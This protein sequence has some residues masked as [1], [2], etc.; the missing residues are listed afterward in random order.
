MLNNKQQF[1]PKKQKDVF[2]KDMHQIGTSQMFDSTIAPKITGTGKLIINK[3]G[4]IDR[5]FLAIDPALNNNPG[6]IDAGNLLNHL[7]VRRDFTF[8][9]IDTDAEGLTTFRLTGYTGTQ[10]TGFAAQIFYYLPLCTKIYSISEKVNPSVK[11]H[12]LSDGHDF[13]IVYDRYIVDPW[14]SEVG[15]GNITTHTGKNLHI[16]QTVFD[17]CDSIDRTKIHDIYGDFINWKR[18]SA[19]EEAVRKLI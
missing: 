11:I 1:I 18:M 12:I 2:N 19:V 16:T 3:F 8:W 7:F 6:I 10:C 17:M 15:V 9:M 13:A 4:T 5:R 14:L